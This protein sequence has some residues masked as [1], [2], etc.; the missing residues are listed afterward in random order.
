QVG[1]Y[2][3]RVQC[4]QP[5]GTA[6]ITVGVTGVA[7]AVQSSADP[8]PHSS[9]LLGR[10]TLRELVEDLVHDAVA[11]RLEDLVPPGEVAGERLA[12]CHQS[13]GRSGDQTGGPADSLS[14]RV[15]RRL[16][17]GD[18]LLDLSTELADRGFAR[19]RDEVAGGMRAGV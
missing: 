4:G 17:I 16:E 10:K 18:D 3:G 14:A 12:R 9:P 6:P 5:F 11:L 2:V 13:L 1:G 8:F 7:T 19:G 15:D